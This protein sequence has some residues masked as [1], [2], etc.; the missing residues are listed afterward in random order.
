MIGDDR[1][2]THLTRKLTGVSLTPSLT[3]PA[4]DL[5]IGDGQRPEGGAFASFFHAPLPRQVAE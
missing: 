1:R 4:L 5:S 3:P 2:T